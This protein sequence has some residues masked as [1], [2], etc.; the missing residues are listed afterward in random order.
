MNKAQ[1]RKMVG[2]E[3]YNRLKPED[4]EF[5]LNTAGVVDFGIKNEEDIR[6]VKASVADVTIWLFAEY[7]PVVYKN[8]IPYHEAEF[9]CMEFPANGTVLKLANHLIHQIKEDWHE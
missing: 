1:L 7:N 5:M 2:K 4:I 6:D 9:Y 8:V 3:V